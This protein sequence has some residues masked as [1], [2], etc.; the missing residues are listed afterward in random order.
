[1][2]QGEASWEPDTGQ[3]NFVY[4]DTWM[5]DVTAYK[6]MCDWMKEDRAHIERE[7]E[8]MQNTSKSLQTNHI[9]DTQEYIA[10]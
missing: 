4:R 9:Y 5:T 3:T 8:C 1:M 6:I 10:C 2:V 7:E